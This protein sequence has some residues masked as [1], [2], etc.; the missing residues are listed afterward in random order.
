VKPSLAFP[1]QKSDQSYQEGVP[2][3]RL[4]QRVVAVVAA[5]E[6]CS[7]AMRPAGGS[8]AVDST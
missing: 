7:K 1:Q 3:W 2:Q 8:V 5:F 6:H 4:Y